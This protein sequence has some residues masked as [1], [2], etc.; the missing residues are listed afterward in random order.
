VSVASDRGEQSVASICPNGTP[1]W[2]RG[3]VNLTRTLG[4]QPLQPL[5]RLALSGEHSVL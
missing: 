5:Y 4:S 2:L 3:S 1:V